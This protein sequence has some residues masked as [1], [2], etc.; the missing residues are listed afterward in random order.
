MDG[1]ER[2]GLTLKP[3]DVLA[4]MRDFAAANPSTLAHQGF[5]DTIRQLALFGMGYGHGDAVET[6]GEFGAMHYAQGVLK[7]RYPGQV[8]NI[9]DVGANVGGFIRLCHSIF[10]VEGRRYVC[11]EP[12]AATFASLKQTTQ[13]WPEVATRHMALGDKPGELTLY[14]DSVGSGL[15]SL[16]KR[17]IDHFGIKMTMS[18][19]VKVSTLDAVADELSLERVHYLKLDVEGHE[20]QCLKG[21]ERLIGEGRVDF[22]QFEFGGANIDSRT[23]FRD[24]WALLKDFSIYRILRDGLL[25][26]E[27]Y[28]EAEEVFATTNYLASRRV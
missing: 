19:T 3:D 10:G 24:F 18:E 16:Y 21:G 22:I 20:L 13:D 17:Q 2:S 28:S 11:F 26:V 23:Y 7:E 5:F 4:F 6:S 12:S 27:R 9:F 15:A 1:S 8:L 25:Q 14:S